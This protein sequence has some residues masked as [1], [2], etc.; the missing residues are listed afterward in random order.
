M[1]ETLFLA[2]VKLGVTPGSGKE[3][4][5]RLVVFHLT[6]TT[7]QSSQRGEDVSPQDRKASA[8]ASTL[9]RESQKNNTYAVKCKLL[10]LGLEM[11]NT[12]VSH[13]GGRLYEYFL[14]T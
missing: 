6:L 14:H 4:W 8:D 1:E 12:L 13:L 7:Q 11:S 3:V 5:L 9:R 10:L 2:S